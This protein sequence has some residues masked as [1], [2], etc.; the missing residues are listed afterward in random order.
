MFFPKPEFTS[1]DL[2]SFSCGLEYRDDAA[3]EAVLDVFPPGE[4]AVEAAKGKLLADLVL[5]DGSVRRGL[6]Q[7]DIGGILICP[8]PASMKQATALPLSY[9]VNTSL[10]LTAPG[11]GG[12][13][14]IDTRPG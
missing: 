3:G 7:H 6:E 11:G 9:S 1:C 4:A 2:A 5:A 14:G 8:S 12:A 10:R 13:P